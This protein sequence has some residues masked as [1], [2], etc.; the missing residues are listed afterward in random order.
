MR[1]IQLRSPPAQK[2]GPLPPSTIT[3]TDLSCSMSENASCKREISASSKALRTSGRS[4]VTRAT[5]S[6]LST[7]STSH[8]EYAELG[9]FDRRIEGGRDRKAEEAPRVRR[10]DHTVVP[11][12]GAGVVGMALLLVLVADRLLELL[13]RFLRGEVALHGRKHARCRLAAHDRDARVGP[14]PQ[15]PR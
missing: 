15:E 6:F 2:A 1:R 4:R 14:H 12:P 13:F 5:P 9:F 7:K 11:E 8:P 10:I 3:R